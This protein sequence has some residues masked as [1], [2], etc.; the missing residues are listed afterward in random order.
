[1]EVPFVFDT[2]DD[3]SV[4]ALTGPAAPRELAAAMHGAWVAFA[5]TGVPG[6]PA[7]TPERRAVARFGVGADPRIEVV[8]DPRGALR[9]LW[10]GIR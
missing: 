4:A 8:D 7:Y 2:L 5:T 10:T 1:M 3:P 9:E 6:W